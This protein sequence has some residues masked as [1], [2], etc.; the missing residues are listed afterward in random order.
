MLLFTFVVLGFTNS[1]I[2]SGVTGDSSRRR[3]QATL[4]AMDMV[5]RLRPLAAGSAELVLGTHADGNNPINGKGKKGGRYTRTW[6]ITE[7]APLPGMLRVVT[8][9]TW[10]D[11]A[12][13][14]RVSLVTYLAPR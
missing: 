4:L 11:P 1:V 3:A 5:E 6:E 8:R 10:R 13:T 9:V 2:N 7:D 12:R 14:P